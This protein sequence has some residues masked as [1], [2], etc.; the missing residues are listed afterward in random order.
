M[1]NFSSIRDKLTPAIGGIIVLYLAVL[2]IFTFKLLPTRSEISRL[3]IKLSD[4]KRHERNL[5]GII[6][7]R[8]AL[9]KEQQRLEER[10]ANL[11]EK[12]PTQYDLPEVLDTLEQLAKSFGVELDSLEHTPLRTGA[13]NFHGTV[14]LYLGAA[15][16]EAIFS[17]LCR[18]QDLFP[19]LHIAEA[20]L[21]Y[22]GSNRF[23]MSVRASL[24]VFST[25]TAKKRKNLCDTL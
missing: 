25:F 9:E 2:A 6:E 12:I 22:A 17:Y 20:V 1:A 3:E 23:Q 24:Q 4:Q 19:S 14:P 15:G 16:G 21:Q 10:I 8:P 5:L 11:A 18:M 13:A 7:G